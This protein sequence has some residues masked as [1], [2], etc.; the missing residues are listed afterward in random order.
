[1][2]SIEKE[3]KLTLSEDDYYLVKEKGRVLECREQL[4]VYF[5]DPSKLHLGLGYFRVRYETGREPVATLKIP[6]GWEGA[7]R[8]MVEIESPLRELGPSLFP[9]PK[10][11][12]RIRDDLPGELGQHILALG[13]TTLRRLGGMRNLRCLVDMGAGVVELDRTRLPDGTIQF[14]VE[15]ESPDDALHAS[16]SSTIREWAP[17]AVESSVGKFSKFLAALGSLPSLL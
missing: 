17:S 2:A 1:M 6:I 7:V 8:R 16:L 3:T 12:I 15:I 13:I 10:R 9:R 5:H 14:E 4:N 11:Q